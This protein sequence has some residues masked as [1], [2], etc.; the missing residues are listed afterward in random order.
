MARIQIPKVAG[1][2]R[3]VIALAGNYAVVNDRTGKN[4]VMIACR[5]KKQAEELLARLKSK[6][7]PS[8]LWI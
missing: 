8:E 1:R 6:D 3:I 7:R 4:H 5:D 2:F